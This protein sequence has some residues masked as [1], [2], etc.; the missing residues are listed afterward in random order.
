M[1]ISLL[2]F[3]AYRADCKQ[4]QSLGKNSPSL[5]AVNKGDDPVVATGLIDG[6]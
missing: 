2:Y 3:S 5:A 6:T 4:Q 1:G